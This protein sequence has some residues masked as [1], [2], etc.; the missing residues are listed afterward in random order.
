MMILRFDRWRWIAAL[1]VL[2][3]SSA[4]PVTAHDGHDHGAPPPPVT[5]TI[6]PRADASSADFEL[7]VVAREGRLVITIDTFRG[8]EPVS[9]A[10]IEIDTPHG[11]QK[12]TAEAEGV[13]SLA[14][15]WVAKPGT[16]DLAVTVQANG[17]VDVLTA[18][19]DIPEMAAAPGKGARPAI[20]SRDAAQ[21][22]ADGALFVPK[23]SQRILALRTEFTE[24]RTFNGTF[25]LPGRIIPDP[26]GVGYVQSSVSGRL[27]PPPGGFPRLG[28]P[29]K[30]GDVL[31]HVHPGV[32]AADV[33]TQQQQARELD[34]QITLV[35]RR[36]ER[37]QQLQNVVAR[38]QIEDAELELAGLLARRANLDRAPRHTEDLV[39]PVSGVIAAVQATAGQIADPSMVI[40]QII[41]PNRFWVEALTYDAQA[42]TG[43]ATARLAN[44]RSITLSYRGT[45]L[46]ERNQSIPIHF[47]VEGDTKGLRA[48][49]FLTVLATLTEEKSGVAVP[50]SAVL[51]GANGQNMVFEHTNAER[52]VPREVRIEPLDA[53]RVLIVSGIGKARRIATQGAELLNQ[54][55]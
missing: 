50:R 3:L 29:V 24:E 33:T 14:A 46:A 22:F 32:G 9:D 7:V 51:R 44:N 6:A 23:D 12:A 34:Q 28:T 25:E 47:G 30:A 38:S 13:Y 26:N 11:T 19:L 36:L 15:P 48:G 16:Y 54:I 52:F 49:Q 2:C 43:T 8:N 27:M 40:F 21:R 20:A 18:T 39:A 5:A 37:L 17:L 4:A 41:D 55:R 45:G 53:N 42:I 31:A 10:E 35:R 1:F